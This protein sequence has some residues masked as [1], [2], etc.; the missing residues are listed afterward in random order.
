M[1]IVA[2]YRLFLL[3]LCFVFTSCSTPSQD[4]PLVSTSSLVEVETTMLPMQKDLCQTCKCDRTNDA[5]VVNCS[6][7]QLN[8]ADLASADLSDTGTL[9]LSH[10]NLERF[11]AV[12]APQLVTLDLSHNQIS[13]LSESPVGENRPDLRELEHLDISQNRLSKLTREMLGGAVSLINLDVSHNNINTIDIDTFANLTSLKT[14]R[15]DHNQLD[16]V[17]SAIKSNYRYLRQELQTLNLRGNPIK[18][19]PEDP[20]GDLKYLHNLDL[21]RMELKYVHPDAFKGLTTGL[22]ELYLNSNSLQTLSIL[23]IQNLHRLTSLSLYDNP[24]VCNCTLED[25]AKYLEARPNISI[26]CLKHTN[27][28]VNDSQNIDFKSQDIS[29]F[30]ISPTTVGTT[31][32]MSSKSF[33]TVEILLGAVGLT[34]LIAIAIIIIYCYRKRQSDH[35]NS[36]SVNAVPSFQLTHVQTSTEDNTKTRSEHFYSSVKSLQ[37]PVYAYAQ[38]PGGLSGPKTIEPAATY[39]NVSSPQRQQPDDSYLMPSCKKKEQKP[40]P[41]PRKC[42]L[43]EQTVL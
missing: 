30:C 38:V 3:F 36:S 35:T 12:Q 32:R 4:Q 21:S 11:P 17:P 37:P 42:C 8:V 24:L 31:E 1:E 6:S 14:L 43:N 27:C 25:L 16:E 41:K 28:N 33:P 7:V 2:V 10:T 23:T 34:V 22:H 13:D 18:E 40:L 39:K 26:V 5:K 29:M 15:L 19:L 20:F 9:I